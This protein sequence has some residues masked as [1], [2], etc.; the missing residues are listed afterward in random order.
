MIGNVRD[1]SNNYQLG[2]QLK[3][4]VLLPN[5]HTSSLTTGKY[6]HKTGRNFTFIAT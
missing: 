1:G 2:I 4:T 5:H 6:N 3:M